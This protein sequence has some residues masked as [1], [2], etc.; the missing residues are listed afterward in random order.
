MD[1]WAR[2]GAFA[3]TRL[4]WSSRAVPPP[5]RPCA[6]FV[7]A[8]LSAIN[9]S[10]AASARPRPGRG[11]LRL[12][13]QDWGAGRH[14]PALRCASTSVARAKNCWRASLRWCCRYSSRLSI[15]FLKSDSTSYSTSSKAWSSA[16]ALR[17]CL[18]KSSLASKMSSMLVSSSTLAPLFASQSLISLVFTCSIWSTSSRLSRSL[19]RAC[20]TDSTVWRRSA[21]VPC[22][23][24]SASSSTAERSLWARSEVCSFSVSTATAR[25]RNTAEGSSLLAGVA[26]VAPWLL[27]LLLLWLLLMGVA[28]GTR[29]W[30]LGGVG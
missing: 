2:I 4:R 3:E 19:F 5:P 7:A 28:N 27:L 24:Y 22:L 20:S 15:S 18:E 14:R 17:T 10:L 25:R 23:S 13:V 11:P 9:S 1:M 12:L 21:R 6:A 16:M 30:L 26:A 8:L 29:C